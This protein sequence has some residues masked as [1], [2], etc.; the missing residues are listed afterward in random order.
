MDHELLRVSDIQSASAIGLDLLQNERQSVENGT[1]LQSR[2]LADPRLLGFSSSDDVD[3]T[4]ASLY[5]RLATGWLGSLP[6]NTATRT[7]LQKE[8]TVRQVAGTLYLASHTIGGDKSITGEAQHQAETQSSQAQDLLSSQ[9]S[10]ASAESPMHA[11]LRDP[12]AKLRHYTSF[13]DT[14]TTLSKPVSK[15]LQHWQ[16]GTNPTEYDYITVTT[17]VDEAIDDE[18]GSTDIEK[19]KR[20]RIED[21]SK[22]GA[23]L[24]DQSAFVECAHIA[25][26]ACIFDGKTSENT[27]SSVAARSDRRTRTSGAIFISAYGSCQSGATRQI[28]R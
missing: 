20:R 16:T 17:A 22:A 3:H 1:G 18:A 28:W 23:D 4:L 21:R 9:S 12:V 7:R 10:A 5:S 13:T 25:K 24:S 27:T 26:D 6:R 19:K 8:K 15:I 14:P 2:L 11:K